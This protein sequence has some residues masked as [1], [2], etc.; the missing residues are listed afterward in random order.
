M[1]LIYVY[2]LGNKESMSGNRED[3]QHKVESY[4]MELPSVTFGNRI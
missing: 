3:S 2:C 4:L 1:A